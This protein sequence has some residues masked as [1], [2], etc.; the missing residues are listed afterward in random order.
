VDGTGYPRGMSGNNIGLYGKIA[1]IIDVF[2]ALTTERVY[3]EAL[4][5]YNALRVITDL[6]AKFDASILKEFILLLG[7][8]F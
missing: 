2:D 8:K 3:Q 7:L 1:G 6:R 5:P 4:T